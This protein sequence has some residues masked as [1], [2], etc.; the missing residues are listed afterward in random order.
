MPAMSASYP[1]P[2]IAREGW[3][4][5]AAAVGLAVASGWLIGWWSA[6]LWLAVLF[7]LQFFRDPPRQA[8]G[9]ARTVVAPADGRI[10]AV[11]AAYD[12]YLKRD[13]LKVSIFMNVFNAHSNRSPVDGEV[14][15]RWYHPGTF[16]NASLDKA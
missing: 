10:V 12:P 8:P 13:T 4:F 3:P 6:P 15:Q 16:V 2:V 1:H 5:L 7:V 11:G 9:D 14:R